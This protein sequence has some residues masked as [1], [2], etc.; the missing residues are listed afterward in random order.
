MFFPGDLARTIRVE[1]SPGKGGIILDVAPPAETFGKAWAHL[2][3]GKSFRSGLADICGES[4]LSTFSKCIAEGMWQADRDFVKGADVM[5]LHRDERHGR[6]LIRFRAVQADLTT[7]VGIFGQLRCKPGTM[8][9]CN[10]TKD[11][12]ELFCAVAPPHRTKHKADRA[13]CIDHDLVRHI[14]KITEA[15]TV[16]SA[17]DELLASRILSAGSKDEMAA[18]FTNQRTTIRDITHGSRKIVER[19]LKADQYLTS[20]RETFIT[21][22]GSITQ[23]IQHSPDL[24]SEFEKAVRD[25]GG[26]IKNLRGAKH[27]F[28]SYAAPSRRCCAHFSSLCHVAQHIMAVRKDAELLNHI[29]AFYRAADEEARLCMAAVA[30]FSQ[31]CLEFTRLLDSEETDSAELNLACSC[32]AKKL[33]VLYLQV[34]SG[35]LAGLVKISVDDS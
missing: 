1:Q 22:R 33:S 5:T 13:S 25:H 30:D 32:L 27:R 14:I 10:T 23:I 11:I 19:S 24:S 9:I 31:D 26:A 15:I 3:E 17:G 6:L 18:Y 28:E 20:L 2:R 29:D 35:V 8:G 16:D 7:R 34:A 12:T 4:K 21:W